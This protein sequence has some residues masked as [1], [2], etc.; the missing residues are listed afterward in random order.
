MITR[1]S[2]S[3]SS[4]GFEFK[5]MDFDCANEETWACGNVGF[6]SCEV[7]VSM[8]RVSSRVLSRLG[9]RGSG[10]SNDDSD[11]TAA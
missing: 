10:G 1:T 11:K 6:I 2:S 5:S 7:N 4:V 3:S 9:R 8:Y